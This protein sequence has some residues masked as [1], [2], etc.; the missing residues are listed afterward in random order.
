MNAIEDELKR[1][2]SI[3]NL[4]NEEKQLL[5]R[6]KWNWAELK[7]LLE[8]KNEILIISPQCLKTTFSVKPEYIVKIQKG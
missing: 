3:P 4:T 5:H 6:I 8:K 2:E 7:L 1:I